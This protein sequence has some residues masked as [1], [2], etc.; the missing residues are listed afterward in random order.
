MFCITSR[1]NGTGFAVAVL[2]TVKMMNKSAIG[3]VG[4][5]AYHHFDGG[6]NFSLMGGVRLTGTYNAK[7]KPFAQ[8]LLGLNHFG[9]SDCSG[10]GCSENDFAVAPGAGVDVPINETFSFHAQID[11]AIINTDFDTVNAQRF[12]FGVSFVPRRK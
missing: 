2:H 8:F 12:W 1:R 5:L 11:F 7:V 4:D 10:D 9:I 3:V 6:G